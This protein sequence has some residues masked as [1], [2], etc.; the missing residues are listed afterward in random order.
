VTADDFLFFGTDMTNQMPVFRIKDYEIG[1]YHEFVFNNQDNFRLGKVLNNA[2]VDGFIYQSEF[3]N[4][5]NQYL[6]E[7]DIE[8][9]GVQQNIQSVL[10][11]GN[12]ATDKFLKF[13][14][15]AK[16]SITAGLEF[17][18]NAATQRALMTFVDNTSGT[19]ELAIAGYSNVGLGFNSPS[20]IRGESGVNSSFQLTPTAFN[21]T[22]PAIS[23]IGDTVSLTTGSNNILTSAAGVVV[24]TNAMTVSSDLELLN[25]K[26]VILKDIVTGTRYKITINSGT[27]TATAI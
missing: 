1:A 14:T 13:K 15:T 5:F 21:A 4:L 18:D 27:I 9:N 12:T 6:T 17:Q 7:A 20:Y 8:T 2:T 23:L 22:T 3:E 24:T 10:S 11:I 16:G 25:Q 26:G 19:D